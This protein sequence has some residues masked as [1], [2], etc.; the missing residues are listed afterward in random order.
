[1]KALL[2]FIMKCCWLLWCGNNYWTAAHLLW[3]SAVLY[4]VYGDVIWSLMRCD[5]RLWGCDCRLRGCDCRKWISGLYLLICCKHLKTRWPQQN[6]GVLYDDAIVKLKSAVDILMIRGKK[7][8]SAVLFMKSLLQLPI[9]WRQLLVRWK[10]ENAQ[11][12][13]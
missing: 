9:R 3:L 2:L 10:N 12:R 6:R 5:C 13:P 4:D 7:Y 11:N 1:M 8:E